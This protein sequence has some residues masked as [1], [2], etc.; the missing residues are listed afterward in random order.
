LISS[1]FIIDFYWDFIN[2][3]SAMSNITNPTYCFTAFSLLKANISRYV[4]D[5]IWLIENLGSVV[6]GLLFSQPTLRK[7]PYFMYFLASSTSQLLTFSFT[8]VPRILESDY[9][10]QAFNTLLCFCQI[11]YYLFYVFATILCYYIILTSIDHYFASSSDI[12][13]SRWSSLKISKRLIIGNALLWCL[14][15]IQV[16]LFYQIQ[17]GDCSF[18]NYI[19]SMFFSVYIP[20][21]DGILPLS[22]MLIFGLLRLNN[23][24]RS[25]RKIRQ[26]L[27]LGVVRSIQIITIK[28]R[29]QQI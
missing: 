22:I 15:Y 25:K 10:V 18:R 16:L 21:N 13:W 20:I 1:C 29:D 28:K 6:N 23:I 17:N 24:L 11:R 26:L 5:L 2:I 14:M 8:R 9:N 12:H 7:N 19:R 27:V 4:M 3:F